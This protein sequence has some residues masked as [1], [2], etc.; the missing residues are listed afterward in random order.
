MTTTGRVPESVPPPLR[1]ATRAAT[2]IHISELVRTILFLVLLVAL[3]V[4]GWTAPGALIA[5]GGG[6]FVAI[7]LSL[8][9]N[10]L[11]RFM[12]RGLAVAV[13]F[14][15]LGVLGVLVLLLVVPPLLAHL[16]EA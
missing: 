15:I 8:P 12:P 16:G 11:T 1:R 2:P 13:V 4:I 6:A 7:V 14:L 10:V 5:V 3:L 9:V